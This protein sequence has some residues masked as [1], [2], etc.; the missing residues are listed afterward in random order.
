MIR[1]WCESPKT[2]TRENEQSLLNNDNDSL[3]N[4]PPIDT[5]NNKNC[6][7]CLNNFLALN[8][9]SKTG[10][11]DVSLLN[12]LQINIPQIVSRMC[13]VV[14]NLTKKFSRIGK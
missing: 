12:K 10:E 1:K 13:E 4:D 11:F 14:F 6:C 5:N 7:V 3:K 9:L 2:P 8:S